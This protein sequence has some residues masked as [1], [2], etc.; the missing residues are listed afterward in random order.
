MLYYNPDAIDAYTIEDCF[1][2]RFGRYCG[3]CGAEM[4]VVRPGKVQCTNAHCGDLY[5]SII[6]SD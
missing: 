4:E 3:I 5:E 6:P 1:Q 2:N